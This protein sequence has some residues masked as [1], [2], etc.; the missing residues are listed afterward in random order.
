MK[1]EDDA[2]IQIGTDVDRSQGA[3]RAIS[4]GHAGLNYY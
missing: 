4:V 1:F 2:Q 3:A